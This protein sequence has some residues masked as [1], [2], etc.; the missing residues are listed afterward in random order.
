MLI[1]PI[2]LG[3]S[4]TPRWLVNK[5]LG[6]TITFDSLYVVVEDVV[7]QGALQGLDT[8]ESVDVKQLALQRAKEALHR[9]VV[10]AVP[11]TGHALSE[12]LSMETSP[13]RGHAVLPPLDA[14]LF[15]KQV[16]PAQLH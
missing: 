15:V 6:R 12:A 16:E 3:L 8:V 7:V 11:F 13:K 4:V 2:A 14:L 9:S 1:P 10:V 5:G